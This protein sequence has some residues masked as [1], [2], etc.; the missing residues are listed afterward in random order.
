[1]YKRGECSLRPTKRSVR[2][3]YWLGCISDKIK[4]LNCIGNVEFREK[5]IG[6]IRNLRGGG[7]DFCRAIWLTCFS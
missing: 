6:C 5:L 2:K 3:I 4:L 1:M 7:N